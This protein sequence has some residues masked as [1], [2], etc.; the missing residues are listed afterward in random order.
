MTLSIAGFER[1]NYG[2][3]Y[4]LPVLEYPI[5]KH[6]VVVDSDRTSRVFS[7]AAQDYGMDVWTTDSFDPA[8]SSY[9]NTSD[10]GELLYLT[11]IGS[12]AALDAM[13]NLS[14]A[15]NNAQQ[16]AL[17][18]LDSGDFVKA[19]EYLND[20]AAFTHRSASIF[21]HRLATHVA[22]AATPAPA[23]RLTVISGGPQ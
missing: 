21:T 2:I 17:L 13:T 4:E 9:R 10:G 8:T 15:L 22:S 23:A 12:A 1:T 14:R 5:A 3:L 20:V 18:A 16:V 19:T 6:L 7:V 11:P